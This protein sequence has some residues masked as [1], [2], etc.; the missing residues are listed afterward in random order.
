MAATSDPFQERGA[1]CLKR[2][3]LFLIEQLGDE[4]L[5]CASRCENDK[6]SSRIAK[7]LVGHLSNIRDRGCFN[8]S[9]TA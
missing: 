6:I 8:L 2:D 4:T 5:R 7:P 1:A 9:A 3:R